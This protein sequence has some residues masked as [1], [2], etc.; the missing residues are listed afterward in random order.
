MKRRYLSGLHNVAP[1]CQS[2]IERN[3]YWTGVQCSRRA[4]TLVNNVTLCTQH[5]N[6]RGSPLDDNGLKV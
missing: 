6:G 4:T 3:G 1:R 2:D 5:A